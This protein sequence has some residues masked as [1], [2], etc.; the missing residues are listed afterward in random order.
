MM[1]LMFV[2]VFRINLP[3]NSESGLVENIA[4]YR[5]LVLLLSLL[6][7]VNK[8]TANK[9][10]NMIIKWDRGLIRAAKHK[11]TN[12]EVISDFVFLNGT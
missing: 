8:F 7:V 9:S 1:T 11:A 12:R 2:T 6:L 3:I 10:N 4:F 5:Q